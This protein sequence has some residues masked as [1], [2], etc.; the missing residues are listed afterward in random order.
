MGGDVLD[1]GPGDGWPSLPMSRFADSVTGVD[2]SAKRV[3]VCGENAR[4]MGVANAR[5]VHVGAGSALPFDDGSF[6]AVVASSSLEQT[7]DPRFTLGELYRVLRPGGRLRFHYE[8]L[9]GYAGQEHEFWAF[10]T[11]SAKTRIILYDRRIADETVF[12]YGLTFEWPL[13]AT[14]KA[15]GIDRRHGHT[16]PDWERFAA[17]Q[18]CMLETTVC[19]LIHPSCRTWKGWLAG[20]GFKTIRATHSGGRAGRAFFDQIAS[21]R[22][23]TD[24]EELDRLLGPVIRTVSELE[25]PEELAPPI[26]AIK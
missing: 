25:A 6:D 7:P 4:R 14:L 17:I 11:P 23:P 12:H 19:T 2:A 24:L 16:I 13:A 5:F 20:A 8:S 22:R 9:E 18:D 1:F 21:E 3:A 15:L 10:E 26:L